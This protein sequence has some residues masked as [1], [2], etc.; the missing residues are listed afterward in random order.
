METP[1]T[2]RINIEAY[3]NACFALKLILKPP[4]VKLRPVGQLCV[5]S[6]HPH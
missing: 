1:G 2:Y 4:K 6:S 5:I 3:L